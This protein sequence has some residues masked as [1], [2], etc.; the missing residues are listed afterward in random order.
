MRP[1]DIHVS[2]SIAHGFL[3]TSVISAAVAHRLPGPG[4]GDPPAGRPHEPVR[5]EIEIVV[6]GALLEG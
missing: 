6:A 4:V 3:T 1:Q 5:G 2:Q